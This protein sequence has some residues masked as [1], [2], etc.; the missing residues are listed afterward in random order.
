MGKLTI[1]IYIPRYVAVILVGSTQILYA[2]ACLVPL[3]GGSYFLLFKYNDIF[4]HCVNGAPIVLFFKFLFFL[5][6]FFI[7]G[8]KFYISHCLHLIIYF[9]SCILAFW[10]GPGPHL[11]K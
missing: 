2:V 9:N 3:F 4:I 10:I 11:L 6:F 8:G 5:N 1:Q 7:A